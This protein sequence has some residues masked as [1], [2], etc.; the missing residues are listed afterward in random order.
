MPPPRKQTAGS[1]SIET[2]LELD[3]VKLTESIAKAQKAIEQ[4]LR[5]VRHHRVD[6]GQERQA[7]DDTLLNL[8]V[9]GERK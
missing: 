3:P 6:V 8:R 2:P 5:E 1:L 7:W 4:R 9:L